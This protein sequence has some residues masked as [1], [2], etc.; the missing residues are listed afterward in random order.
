MYQDKFRIYLIFFYFE[1]RIE[2]RIEKIPWNNIILQ[3]IVN[4]TQINLPVIPTMIIT[5]VYLIKNNVI[6]IDLAFVYKYTR[7]ALRKLYFYLF[8]HNYE[9]TCF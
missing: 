3:D 2:F 6:V 9:Y 8:Y 4:I 7:E 5:D 1:Y